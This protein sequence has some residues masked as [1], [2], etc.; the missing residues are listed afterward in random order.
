MRVISQKEAKSL[1]Q[2]CLLNNLL[3]C[4]QAAR[5]QIQVRP[6]PTSK[7]RHGFFALSI[8]S[9]KERKHDVDYALAIKN[10]ASVFLVLQYSINSAAVDPAT[11]FMSIPFHFPS[12]YHNQ[13]S[14]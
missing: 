6:P 14:Y 2:L 3:L 10:N 7:E 12:E 1:P 9:T 5:K 13:F 4:H 8:I 11:R